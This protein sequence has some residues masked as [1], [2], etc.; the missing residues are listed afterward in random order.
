[1]PYCIYLRKSRVDL[2]LEAR[3]ELETLA[4][5]EK[6]LLE[7]AERQ[8]LDV[9][10]IHK[11]IVSGETIASRPA[12][13]R[14]L[15][16]VEN[17]QWDGVLVM[18]IERLARGDPIDQGVVARTF[19]N[20]G[21]RIITPMKTYDPG[22]EFDEEYFEFGLFMSRRE[23]KTINRRIQRGRLQSAREGK[24]LGS[25][26]PFGYDKVRLATDKGYTL[27][28]NAESD[29]VRTIFELYLQGNGCSVIARRLDYLHIPTRSGSGWSKATIRDILRNP[30]YMGKIRW[31]YRVPDRSSQ[32]GRTINENCIL[33]DGLHPPLVEKA[34]FQK[35]QLLLD[36]AAGLPVKK[37]Y[38][39][40]NALAGLGYCRQCGHTLTRLGPNKHCPYDTLR[41]SNSACPTVSAPLELV[42]REVI[43]QL[44]E[45]TGRYRISLDRI[46]QD[47]CPDHTLLHSLAGLQAD[48][49]KTEKQLTAAFD[50]LEQGVYTQD[51]FRQRH[52]LLNEKL[53]ELRDA[54]AGLQNEA[55][56]KQKH[57]S[58]QPEPPRLERILDGYFAI[59]DSGIRNEILRSI[60]V[61][62]DYEKNV[63]N[64]RGGRNNCNFTV[65]I[66]PRLP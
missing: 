55:E 31:S 42:E 53:S 23:Y 15:E 58:N 10:K 7:L 9:K 2:E 43:R 50:L 4:R 44:D 49:V 40:Q 57:D 59:Q 25:T 5:H 32:G 14:L 45:H 46:P 27:R 24:F 34:I 66:Y 52:S 13:R 37:E 19:R 61:K 62:F 39:L 30:V 3:G 12:M 18:E 60:L 65:T 47:N 1:M 11:E 56:E 36:A 20:A 35:V 33:V 54:Y 17:G 48:I 16:E 21:T 8:H 41:C 63:P 26:P 29:A 51:L 22:N 64:R 6:T 28:P 38:R